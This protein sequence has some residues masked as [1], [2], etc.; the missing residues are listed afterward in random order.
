M[1]NN[2]TINVQYNQKERNLHV[3]QGLNLKLNLYPLVT[4]DAN[5]SIKPCCNAP[6]KYPDYKEDSCGSNNGHG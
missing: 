2:N 4:R 5:Q 6:R 1:S 3:Q